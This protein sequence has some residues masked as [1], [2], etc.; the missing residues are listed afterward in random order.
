MNPSNANNRLSVG[1][2][3]YL[4]GDPIA[5]LPSDRPQNDAPSPPASSILDIPRS[6][7]TTPPGLIL[8]YGLNLLQQLNQPP[9]LPLSPSKMHHHPYQQYSHSLNHNK[10]TLINAAKNTTTVPASTTANSTF[11]RTTG[12]NEYNHDAVKE[13]QLDGFHEQLLISYA[14]SLIWEAGAWRESTFQAEQP[15][16]S[17]ARSKHG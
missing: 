9:L 7:T 11:V 1:L 6:T 16:I 5:R 17:L 15:P 13:L 3:G 2:E 4:N 8:P 12:C 10:N 14:Q